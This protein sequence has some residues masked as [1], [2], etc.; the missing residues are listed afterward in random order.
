MLN[1]IIL[2]APGS[3]KGTQSDLLVRTFGLDHIS[4]GEILR[5]EIK[6][7]TELGKIAATY[8]N[9]GQLVPDELTVDILSN[10]LDKRKSANGSIFDGFPR[11]IAQAEALKLML[12]ARNEDIS[13]VIE[14]VVE[15]EQLVQRLLERG[16][17]EG[18]SDDNEQTIRKRLE[19]YHAQ[20][21]PLS[22]YYIKEGTHFAI[23]G[24]GM[25]E[26]IFDRIKKV[27]Q[28]L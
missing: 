27:C 26:E 15:E 9:N 3:G 8:I 25:V 10:T 22:S 17:I 12:N 16:Q 18:R 4:T 23:D 2:G 21:E 6:N 11:T 1:I 28:T 14:L 24:S 5:A 13:A 20:T 7:E 19:V